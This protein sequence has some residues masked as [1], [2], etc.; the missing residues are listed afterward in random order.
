MN[1]H[2][3]DILVVLP[4]F[5]LIINLDILIFSLFFCSIFIFLVALFIYLVLAALI[6][7]I[8][9]SVLWVFDILAFHDS[10]STISELVVLILSS[11][12]FFRSNVL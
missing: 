8:T 9:L 6:A 11:P 10:L 1:I 4:A 12:L 7:L 2:R 3:I 5:V